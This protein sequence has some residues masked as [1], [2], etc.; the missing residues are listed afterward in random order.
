MSD[1]IIID[2][3]LIFSAL[4]RKRSRIREHLLAHAGLQLFCPR[5]VFVE[6]FKHKERIIDVTE[7]EENEVLEFLS[8]VL[9]RVVF[10]DEGL[11]EMGT[12]MKARQLCIET[13]ENDT[14]F[15]ALA[16]HL[17]GR[18]WTN[19]QELKQGLR[20]RGFNQFFEPTT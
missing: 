3:N 19:D 16:L 17:E 6:L 4:L 20:A 9:S 5:F 18:L 8:A 2:T 15:V 1:S 7:L 11:I 13:D 14:P 10:I 12:W